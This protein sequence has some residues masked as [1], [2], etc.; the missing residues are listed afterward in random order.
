MLFTPQQ[1][2]GGARFSR[3]VLLGN[4]SEDQSADA[5]ISGDFELKKQRGRL[6][7]KQ[8]ER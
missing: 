7:I 4:W 5:A 1:L 2:S 6:M 3:G 8:R